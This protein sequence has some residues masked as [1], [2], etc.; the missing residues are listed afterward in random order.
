MSHIHI[1]H[2]FLH[3]YP[4]PKLFLS[5]SHAMNPE[6]SERLTPPPSL[7]DVSAH[8]K[9]DAPR[10]WQPPNIIVHNSIKSTPVTI[11]RY[12]VRVHQSTPLPNSP[13]RRRLFPAPTP[14]KK[15]T[16]PD[17]H[18]R[19][20]RIGNGESRTQPL[21]AAAKAS[22]ASHS[23]FNARLAMAIADATS[24]IRLFRDAL[25]ANTSISSELRRVIEKGLI[26]HIDQK[27]S[28]LFV[29]RAIRIHPSSDRQT[30]RHTSQ[31]TIIAN[32]HLFA[33]HVQLVQITDF[34][35][36]ILFVP[37][38]WC[39]Q[40]ICPS[41]SPQPQL[42]ITPYK[43]DLISKTLISPFLHDL[44]LNCGLD[45]WQNVASMCDSQ[46]EIS[47]THHSC[48]MRNEN[49]YDSCNTFDT[50]S[51]ISLH[52]TCINLSVFVDFFQNAMKIAIIRDTNSHFALFSTHN[53]VHVSEDRQ[54]LSNVY[55]SSQR[56][57]I[58]TLVAMLSNTTSHQHLTEK[59][60]TFKTSHTVLNFSSCV[61][62]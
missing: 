62:I 21:V 43:L 25:G 42:L 50:F 29:A 2:L 59:L 4:S 35:K 54:M 10:I 27:H 61:A 44:N 40:Y 37:M 28:D 13:V 46:C 11:P 30:L 53:A 57:P 39:A 48:N 58:S 6:F 9:A 23:V 36:Y 33:E 56:I 22:R 41:D 20:F 15:R 51:E 18:P 49:Q 8:K 55:V 26:L 47:E 34:T 31:L 19:S 3:S 17:F 1:L 12:V 60:D 52:N 16:R 38:P 32:T 5:P 7:S 45:A 24:N 14:P